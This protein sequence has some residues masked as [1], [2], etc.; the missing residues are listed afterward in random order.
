MTINKMPAKMTLNK[1]TFE[2]IKVGQVFIS[3]GH[4]SI[5]KDSLAQVESLGNNQTII[6][7]NGYSRWFN[8]DKFNK[9]F[10]KK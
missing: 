8:I 3:R 4:F 1:I 6:K 5:K 9:A 10:K 2:S 7:M